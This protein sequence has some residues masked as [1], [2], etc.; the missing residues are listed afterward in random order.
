VQTFTLFCWLIYDLTQCYR[1]RHE[2][3]AFKKQSLGRGGQVLGGFTGVR[4]SDE[5]ALVRHKGLFVAQQSCSLNH[6]VVRES[7]RT[8]SGSS[9]TVRFN[10]SW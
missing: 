6:G 9:L 4:A 3:K 7:H 2:E 10:L 1:D 8:I 5:Q